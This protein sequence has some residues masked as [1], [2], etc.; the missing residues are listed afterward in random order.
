LLGAVAVPVG[1]VTGAAI[2][3]AAGSL[4]DPGGLGSDGEG[5]A[6][7]RSGGAAKARPGNRAAK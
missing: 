5:S 1:A 6:S 4:A 2:G 7:E 3:A